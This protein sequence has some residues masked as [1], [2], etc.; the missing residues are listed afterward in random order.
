MKHFKVKYHIRSKVGKYSCNV[1]VFVLFLNVY[2]YELKC[3]WA[4]C[5]QLSPRS[6]EKRARLLAFF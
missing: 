3:V 1:L 4:D 5:G 2:M 6:Q